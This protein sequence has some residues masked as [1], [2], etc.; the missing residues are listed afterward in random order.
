MH[1]N[2]KHMQE[3]LDAFNEEK[4]RLNLTNTIQDEEIKRISEDQSDGS[5]IKNQSTNQQFLKLSER[6]NFLELKSNEMKLERDKLQQ[7]LVTKQE[8]YHK[9]LQTLNEEIDVLKEREESLKKTNQLL[10]TGLQEYK[11]ANLDSYGQH[12]SQAKE[13][14]GAN[15]EAN[16]ILEERVTKAEA[17]SEKLRAERLNA[18]EE[19]KKAKTNLHEA[20]MK[21]SQMRMELKIAK[22]SVLNKDDQI[23]QL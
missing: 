7:E 6:V 10:E 21:L 5:L 11:Q 20:E 13:G 18:L 8:S 3:Q 9:V 1:E 2:T 19:L 4:E 16:L 17:E 23:K 14:P 12:K 15:I 22:D